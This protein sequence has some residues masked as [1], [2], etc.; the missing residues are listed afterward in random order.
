MELE[1]TRKK[2]LFIRTP[3]LSRK[4]FDDLEVYFKIDSLQPSGSFKDRGIGHMISSLIEE[5]NVELLITS[6]GGNAGHSVAC[7]GRKL[8]IPVRVY[9]PITTKPMMIDKIKL[10]GAQVIVHGENWNEADSLARA[11][12]SSNV[13]A[14]YIPPFDNPLIWQG[15]SSLIDELVEDFGVDNPPDEILVSVGGGGLL[16]GVQIGLQ[17]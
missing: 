16:A 14:R 15:H 11:E 4:Y 5:A 7:I 6:S 13:K 12:L 8:M 9:V 3:I 1:N 2:G 10:T 17:R